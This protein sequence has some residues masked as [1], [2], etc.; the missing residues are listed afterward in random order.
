MFAHSGHFA[1]F[2][3]RYMKGMFVPNTYSCGSND[4]YATLVTPEEE[5]QNSLR[6]RVL[7]ES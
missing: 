7:G 5:T 2:A 6:G 4:G 1:L 3:D